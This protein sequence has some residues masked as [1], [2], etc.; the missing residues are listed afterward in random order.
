MIIVSTSSESQ[1]MVWVWAPL[2]SA[3]SCRDHCSPQL[4]QFSINKSDFVHQQQFPR[5]RPP[6]PPSDLCNEMLTMMVMMRRLLLLLVLLV[7][8]NGRPPACPLN[9]SIHLMSWQRLRLVVAV[10]VAASAV[11]AD[12][13]PL[14][15]N[16]GPR[17]F[18]I[19]INIQWCCAAPPRDLF[20]FFHL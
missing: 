16:D 5:Y 6:P 7:G 13:L 8:V 14:D 17:L 3:Q 2:K 11:A 20:L 19:V 12:F 15:S 1:H 9:I 10:V 4:L 18:I